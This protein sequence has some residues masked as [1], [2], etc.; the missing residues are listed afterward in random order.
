RSR[1][2]LYRSS[3]SVRRRGAAVKYLSH[4]RSLQEGSAKL[5]PSHHGT[6]HL[7]AGVSPVD[8][9][10]A[11]RDERCVVGEQEPSHLRDL[12]GPTEPAQWMACDQLGPEIIGQIG[13]QWRL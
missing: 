1:R 3:G 6:R 11:S 2:S 4:S 7:E 5:I 10:V 13:K 9:I 12:F 8:Q